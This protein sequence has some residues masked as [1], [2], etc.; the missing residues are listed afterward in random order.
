M[1]IEATLIQAK[2]DS[3][4]THKSHWFKQ[5]WADIVDSENIGVSSGLVD[6]FARN[7]TIAHPWTNDINADSKA[8]YHLCALEF[9]RALNSNT[10]E[11]IIIDPPFSK[12]MAEKHYEGFGANLYASD[13]KLMSKVFRECSRILKHGGFILKFGYNCNRPAVGFVLK[14]LWV[15]NKGGMGN[16]TIVSL[17]IKEQETLEKWVA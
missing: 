10:Y 1:K 13:S 4:D 17:W 8:E 9:L 12:P 15:V 5:I 11:G 2:S 7:C 16:D 14:S 6:P 3:S